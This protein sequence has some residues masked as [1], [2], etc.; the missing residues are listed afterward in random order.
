MLLAV[1]ELQF[2]VNVTFDI[3]F[4]NGVTFVVLFFALGDA[5]FDLDVLIVEIDAQR[6]KR[7]SLAH[8]FAKDFVDF[9]A[10]KQQLAFARRIVVEMN[11]RLFVGTDMSF[12]EPRFAIFDAGIAPPEL[13]TTSSNGFDLTAG[14]CNACGIAL[15]DEVFMERI[16][17]VGNCFARLLCA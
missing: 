9:F 10:T 17:V 7:I 15:F 16:A 3:A 11:A 2:A 6:Y 12:V 5:D 13:A 1:P 14:E 4:G 8:D